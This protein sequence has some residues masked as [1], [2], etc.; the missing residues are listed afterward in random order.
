M[1]YSP[2]DAKA[3]AAS[4]LAIVFVITFLIFRDTDQFVCSIISL[5]VPIS[6]VTFL[7]FAF[8]GEDEVIPSEHLL[9]VVALLAF[10]LIIGTISLC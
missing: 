5:V 2:N 4:A 9:V 6:V 7:F 10:A 8:F 3:I 1:S